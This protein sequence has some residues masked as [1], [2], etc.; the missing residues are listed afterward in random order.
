MGRTG[1]ALRP[2]QAPGDAVEQ[3]TESEADWSSG[4][5]PDG[6]A[7]QLVRC[8]SRPVAA[9]RSCTVFIA[10]I[11]VAS[12]ASPIAAATISA[13]PGTAAAA[14]AGLG[15]VVRLRGRPPGRGP[16]L[17]IWDHR[18]PFD[19]ENEPPVEVT[20]PWPTSAAT[21]TDVFGHG[22]TT[23]CQ[24]GQ[25]R[26]PVSGTPLFVEPSCDSNL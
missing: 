20:W 18:D 10:D 1:R 14:G 7:S 5:G 11:S 2:G 26:L 15:P 22:W 23:R 24:D 13:G 25:I 6:C 3:E 16:L 19:G 4:D 17:V 12:S 8:G 9:A 21:V